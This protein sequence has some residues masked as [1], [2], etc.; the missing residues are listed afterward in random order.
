MQLH[1]LKPKT[2]NKSSKRI[3]RGGKRGKT[4]GRGHKGQKAHGGHGI[5]PELRDTIKKLPKL[6]GHG[7][8]RART[9]NASA[10]RPQT[11]TFVMLNRVADS[12]ETI[13]PRLLLAKGAVR[14]HNGKVP[15]VKIVATG[16]LE[17]KILVEGCAVSA[18]ARKAIEEKGGTVS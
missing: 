2:A 4:S 3:G 18:S 7:Q 14:R 9:V 13:T 12:G 16:A 11:V 6:R 17:K 15:S 10:Q 5:R 1:E 8:N